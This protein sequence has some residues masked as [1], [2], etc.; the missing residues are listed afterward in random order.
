MKSLLLLICLGFCASQAAAKDYI[1]TDFGV[2]R[3]SS[4]LSTVA[5]QKVIDKA[6][7]EG[8]GTIVIPKGVFLSGALFFKPHTKLK[9]NQGA[10]LKGS[11]DIANYPFI[12]S[13]MEGQSLMY[14][15]ALINAYFVDNFSIT[16]PGTIDG[17]GLKFWKTFWAHRKAMRKIGKSSTNL[18]VSR[19]RLIFI[20]GCNNVEIQGAKLH[21][22]GFWTTH[23]YKSNHVLIENCDIRSPYEPVPA[24]STD[25]VDIDAC[26]DVTIRKCYIS[27]ND[28]GIAIKGGKGPNAHKLQQNGAVEN[29]LIEDCEFGPVHAALTM[30]S[31]CIH[32][33]NITMR[34]CKINNEQPILNL[35]MRP[36]TY[37]VYEG[38][39]IENITGKCGT[40]IKLSPWKQ[41][42]NMNGSEE[43]PFGTIRN[44][45][46]S[47]VNVAC[48]RIGVMDGNP[49]DKVSNI[50]FKN[51]HATVQDTTFKN[52]YKDVKFEDV[53]V[54][55]EE[56]KK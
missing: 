6:A 22:A 9:L 23:L 1:I 7:L 17:N 10:V 25:G 31:E 8:G 34:N 13:R 14:Y 41:F 46:F 21:N 20:W 29:V 16:G 19:P 56:F 36:D 47:N 26:K 3:D 35:K 42:F 12:P 53:T 2:K 51:I 33:N 11:N 54:N 45:T 4:Q 39:T 15:A 5:I 55:G 37:Q 49:T 40:L 50:L 32:S 18:E 52:V 30:G 24:P 38:I 48:N 27:V 43:Q 44:I 28:D